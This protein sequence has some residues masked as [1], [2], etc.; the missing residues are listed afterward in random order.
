[1]K[2]ATS[3]VQIIPEVLQIMLR[4]FI[5]NAQ[6]KTKQKFI[7]RKKEEN[8]VIFFWKMNMLKVELLSKGIFVTHISKVMEGLLICDVIF[9][10]GVGKF[11]TWV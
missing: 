6:G 3:K 2:Q 1:M 11:V 5:R 7:L 9:E 4:L 10:E 8:P